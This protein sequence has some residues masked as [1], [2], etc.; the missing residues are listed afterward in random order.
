MM[1]R[2]FFFHPP[3]L[4]I[5]ATATVVA[6]VLL[7]N[8][9]FN[10][11]CYTQ[12]EATPTHKLA[13]KWRCALWWLRAQ[14]ITK[15]IRS[16][17]PPS[18]NRPLSFSHNTHTCV[19]TLPH[20]ATPTPPPHTG[21]QKECN[22]EWKGVGEA[23]KYLYDLS[24][25]DHIGI[26]SWQDVKIQELTSQQCFY[27]IILYIYS[28]CPWGSC[29]EDTWQRPLQQRHLGWGQDK[30]CQPAPKFSHSLAFGPN[31]STWGNVAMDT[32]C[33][34]RTHEPR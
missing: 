28:T 18:L 34:S 33:G 29:E 5:F 23:S 4:V 10:F 1:Q 2:H 21:E 20:A 13:R 8:S 9:R 19:H 15:G 17:E 6:F 22:E 27:L 24:W 25:G 26:C 14:K 12:R 31:L 7:R 32:D 30:A 11:H 16:Y 3:S